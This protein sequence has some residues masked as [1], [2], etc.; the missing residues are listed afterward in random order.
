MEALSSSVSR[1]LRHVIL[2]STHFK[3]YM[4][5]KT[6]TRKEKW[7][8]VSSL[9]HDLSYRQSLKDG[10][11]HLFVRSLNSIP[12]FQSFHLILAH[13]HDLQFHR[14]ATTPELSLSISTTSR[15]SYFSFFLYL[16]S[17]NLIDL[18]GLVNFVEEVKSH[19][20]MYR[21]LISKP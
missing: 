21:E 10:S 16:I 6:R 7:W 14:L 12:P 18:S 8:M 9:I 15:S 3:E 19:T 20:S 5:W 13:I 17:N 4:L 1:S 2:L 11:L